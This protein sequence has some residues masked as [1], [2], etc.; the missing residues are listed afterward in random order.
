MTESEFVDYHGKLPTPIQIALSCG[1]IVECCNPERRQ[2][3]CACLWSELEE[4]GVPGYPTDDCEEII[5][6]T[7]GDLNADCQE[8]R[9]VAATD[10]LHHFIL[11]HQAQQQ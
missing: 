11:F 3:L 10:L 7:F 9:S 5:L 8:F 2:L 1:H 4:F 6:D